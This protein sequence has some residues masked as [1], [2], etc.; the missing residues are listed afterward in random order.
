MS[1]FEFAPPVEI[2]KQLKS[3]ESSAPETMKEMVEAGMDIMHS[4]ILKKAPVETGATKGS[5]QKSG[6]HPDDL[7][8]WYANDHF[9]GYDETKKYFRKNA[10]GE[11]TSRKVPYALK[12]LAAE[13]GTPT[14]KPRPFL[15]PAMKSA[16][17]EAY[18][19]MQ[20]VYDRRAE[21]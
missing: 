1:Q 3:L 16:E 9:L 12:A 8:T 13:Y 20:E 6:G 7:G 18:R 17:K 5:L 10:K 2:L 15:R 11:K 19:A 4:V 14:Q 21:K